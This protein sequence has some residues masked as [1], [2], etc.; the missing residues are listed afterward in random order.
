LGERLRIPDGDFGEHLPVDGNSGFFEAVHKFAIGQTLFAR[1]GVY[2]GYPKLAQV[3]FFVFAVLISGGKRLFNL[4]Y[5]H[6]KAA[7]L[8]AIITFA[9]FKN[10]FLSFVSWNAVF[11]SHNA[12]SPFRA[13][14]GAVCG[15]EAFETA[16]PEDRSFAWPHHLLANRRF[17]F[18]K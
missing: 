5:R 15:P 2:P 3:A 7:A 16:L 13:R 9:Q 12:K 14:R 6:A 11:Y 17:A 10:P 18:G 1:G 4:L 8:I